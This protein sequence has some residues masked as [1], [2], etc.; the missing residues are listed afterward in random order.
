[1]VSVG[2][3]WRNYNVPK[4]KKLSLDTSPSASLLCCFLASL[5]TSKPDKNMTSLVM[6]DMKLEEDK[7]IARHK[8]ENEGDVILRMVAH[9]F[10]KSSHI[11]HHDNHLPPIH[12]IQFINLIVKCIQVAI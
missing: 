9:V 8:K 3:L 5:N 4:I 7:R 6:L 12:I 11:Y 1:M 2:R 10:I